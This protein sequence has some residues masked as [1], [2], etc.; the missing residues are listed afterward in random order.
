MKYK[1]NSPPATMDRIK[2]FANV[3]WM[4]N[5]VIAGRR[6]SAGDGVYACDVKRW[7]HRLVGALSDQYCCRCWRRSGNF[8]PYGCHID[9]KLVFDT[10]TSGQC[11]HYEAR[12]VSNRRLCQGG[13]GDDRSLFSGGVD[14]SLFL[15]WNS[16]ILY[17]FVTWYMYS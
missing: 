16:I 8:C 6:C 17:P 14:H 10:D 2:N 3:G 12:G 7:R 13:C 9:V 11:P 15:L 1:R 5:L 4:A